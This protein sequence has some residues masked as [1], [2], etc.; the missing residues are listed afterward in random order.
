LRQVAQ[1]I[2]MKNLKT[3]SPQGAGR[4]ST[5]ALAPRFLKTGVNLDDTSVWGYIDARSVDGGLAASNPAMY[6]VSGAYGEIA[7]DS[8]GAAAE[9]SGM[10]VAADGTPPTLSAP[11]GEAGCFLVIGAS[12]GT[13]SGIYLMFQRI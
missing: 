9:S 1:A 3:G 12:F 11:V 7:R 2:A 13:A 10:T 5:M 6:V 4:V 8:C